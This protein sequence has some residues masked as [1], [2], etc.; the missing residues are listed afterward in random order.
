MSFVNRSR[1]MGERLAVHGVVL[2]WDTRGRRSPRWKRRRFDEADVIDVSV[3]GA[4]LL[5]PDNQ[6]IAV[7]HRVTI[8]AGGAIGVV[9]VKRI[10][11]VT[12]GPLAIFGVEFV[13]LEPALEALLFSQLDA[14]RPR[15]GNI[16]WR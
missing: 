8:V 3:S 9:R 11:P 10:A 16:V 5:A 15:R 1:R 4:Q 7:G 12:H 2:S 6:R 14:E 13:T